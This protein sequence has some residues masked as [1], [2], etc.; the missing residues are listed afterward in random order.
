MADRITFRSAFTAN[1]PFA[2]FGATI[3]FCDLFWEQR[4]MT[5]IIAGPKKSP[6]DLGDPALISF[7]QVIIHEYMHCDVVGFKEHIYDVVD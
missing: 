1:P 4:F 3:T 6:A 5:S 7:E 2:E